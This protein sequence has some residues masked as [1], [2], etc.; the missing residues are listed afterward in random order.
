[1]EV[2]DKIAWQVDG[3]IDEQVAI[4]HFEFMFK[5]LNDNDLL[6]KQGKEI[7]SFGLDGSESLSDNDVTTE[8]S[9]FLKRYYDKYIG[10]I[11]YGINEDITLLDSMLLELRSKS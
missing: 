9:Q 11:A 8:G 1:M 10:S 2:Y 6:S 7:L 5:W 4:N 3:G